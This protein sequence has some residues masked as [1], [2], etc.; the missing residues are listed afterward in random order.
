MVAEVPRAMRRQYVPCCTG[1]SDMSD[2]GQIP[3]YIRQLSYHHVLGS[4]IRIDLAISQISA[5]YR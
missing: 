1:D 2:A 4:P 5:L 3:R